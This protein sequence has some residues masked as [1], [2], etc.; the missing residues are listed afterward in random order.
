MR[1][2]VDQA[3]QEA[4]RL[5]QEVQHFTEEKQQREAAAENWAA[6]KARLEEALAAAR[7]EAD[8]VVKK[9]GEAEALRRDCEEKQTQVKALAEQL[10]AA[11]EHERGAPGSPAAPG[12]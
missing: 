12:R 10:K 5:R 11:Q 7:A 8:A 3:Q 1:E 2:A 4:E 6:E 9:S